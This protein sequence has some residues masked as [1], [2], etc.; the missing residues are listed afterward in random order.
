[1]PSSDRE[2]AELVACHPRL[3]DDE[4]AFARRHRSAFMKPWETTPESVAHG[5]LDD[6]T[7]DW[8]AVVDAMLKTGG[9]PLVVGEDLLIEANATA[10]EATGVNVDHTGSAGLAGVMQAI[11][12]DSRLSTERIAVVFSG[13]S[14]TA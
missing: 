14:R 5:I 11:A 1:M 12:L 4:L 2:R 9:W 13:V 10:R 8:A 3:V 7:Y 6:E